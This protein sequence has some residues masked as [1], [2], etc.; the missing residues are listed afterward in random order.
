MQ[1]KLNLNLSQT[2]IVHGLVVHSRSH[3]AVLL[4]GFGVRFA[5]PVHVDQDFTP[6]DVVLFENGKCD[7]GSAG[8]T[9]EE[10]HKP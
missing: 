9:T 2:L 8:I 7:P 10:V 4:G 6:I 5:Y 1:T 3:S